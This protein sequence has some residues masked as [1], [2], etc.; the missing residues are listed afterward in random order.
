MQQRHDGLLKLRSHLQQ[1]LVVGLDGK[2]RRD[3]ADVQRAAERHQHVDRPPIVH[4][5][6]GVHAFGELGADC[7]KERKRGVTESTS[8]FPLTRLNFT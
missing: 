8:V 6:D 1:E 5:H 7:H 4:A 3:E 2:G